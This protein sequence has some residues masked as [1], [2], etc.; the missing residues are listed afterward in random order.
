LQPKA[1]QKGLG[2]VENLPKKY[3][4]SL[5]LRKQ[6]K[7]M[8]YFCFLLY[9][10]F[11]ATCFGQKK[12][13]FLAQQLNHNRVQTAKQETDSAAR[14]LFIKMGLD[15]A[16]RKVFIRIFK[17]E[18]ILEL[19][20]ENPKTNLFVRLKT[21]PVCA[22][23]GILGGKNKTGDRQVPEGF[24]Y[25][26]AYNPNSSFFLSVMINYP[27][28]YDLHWK[29]T[30]SAI[31][32]HGN[33]A[34]IGCIAIEDKPIKELYWILI[35]AKNAGQANIPV[36]IFPTQLTDN[37]L[38]VLK[39]Q[40]AQESDKLIFWENLRQGYEYFENHK[41]LPNVSVKKGIYVFK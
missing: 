36:H 37:Q 29:K 1:L 9:F 4:F 18:A 28:E 6:I 24:Y 30:G 2:D 12:Q 13:T 10:F 11:A 7:F 16:P 39:E 8:K 20:V 15:Y 22:M 23:S 31:C 40:F 21:Y 14:Q 3:F 41:K 35:Q 17:Q 27:N 26:N 25:I 32:I 33:C 5:L 34:S 38:T 19:W